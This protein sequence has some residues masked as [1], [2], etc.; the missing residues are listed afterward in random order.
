MSE[1]DHSYTNPQH[2]FWGNMIMKK[3]LLKYP[4]F[5]LPHGMAI[6]SSLIFVKIQWSSPTSPNAKIMS[7]NE[8]HMHTS[9]DNNYQFSLIHKVNI[10][11]IV[12]SQS[13]LTSKYN[14]KKTQNICFSQ[15]PLWWYLHKSK[16]LFESSNCPSPSHLG[17]MFIV[18]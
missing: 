2:V 15:R 7:F 16:Y 1:W 9:F 3:F 17:T 11:I 14:Y 8:R 5:S 10:Y 12:N 6:L 4:H 13:L 18:L